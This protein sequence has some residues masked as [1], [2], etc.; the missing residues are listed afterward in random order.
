MR[1]EPSM[2]IWFGI[3]VNL[4]MT[5]ANFTIPYHSRVGRW[6]FETNGPEW[7]MGAMWAALVPL[8]AAIYFTGG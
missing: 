6:Y 7:C 5:V 4:L 8:A 2:P 1:L 3:A